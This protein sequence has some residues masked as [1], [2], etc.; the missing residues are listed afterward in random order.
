MKII[1]NTAALFSPEE[2]EKLGIRILPVSVTVGNRSF[3][4]YID[5]DTDDFTLLLKGEERAFS[6]Q[7]SVGDVLDELEDCEEDVIMLTVGDGLSGEYN[8]AMGIRNTLPNKER[9][10]VIDSGSLG[11]ALHYLALKAAEMRGDGMSAQ[12]I[13]PLLTQCAKSS[14]SYVIPAD[15][16]YL[17]KSGRIHRLTS[18]I[19]GALN[20]LPVLTQSEDRKKIS[21][22]KVRRTW[23]SAV[24]VILNHMKENGVNENSLIHVLYADRKE[25]AQQV[26]EQV[27]E[28]F[29]LTENVIAQLPPSLATHGGPG[30]I[31][32]QSIGKLAA[33]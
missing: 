4:D 27:Q 14:A 24:G 32:L 17:R 18:R 15:F 11:G 6:S 30:C 21:L 2:G 13:V 1:T 28:A 7:P 12:Q 3:Q 33:G 25:L 16:Q 19:G 29:P 20:L 9:I 23:K 22:M 5:I 10:H 26:R 8:T 31:V